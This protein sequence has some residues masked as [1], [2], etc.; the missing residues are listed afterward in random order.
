MRAHHHKG[1]HDPFE[2]YRNLREP[3]EKMPN[4]L[5]TFHV[6]STHLK[7][8]KHAF[9]HTNIKDILEFIKSLDASEF[10]LLPSYFS[11]IKALDVD[12]LVDEI[13]LKFRDYSR[14]VF[15]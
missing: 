10:N 7:L 6:K 5:A 12:F 8:Y 1:V 15:H 2:I 14:D 9:A 3:A 13:S 11:S 4:S